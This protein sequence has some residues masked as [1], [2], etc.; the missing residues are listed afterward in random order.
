MTDEQLFITEKPSV[1]LA[2]A[3]YFENS[4]SNGSR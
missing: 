4:T 3:D 1:A 2:L